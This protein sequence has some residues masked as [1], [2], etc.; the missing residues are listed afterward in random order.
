MDGSELAF[1]GIA[2]QA[3]LIRAREV[4]SREL[5]ELCLERIDRLD[6][7]L[8]AFRVVLSDS[9]LTEA[10]RADALGEDDGEHPL[11]GV[12]IAVK[13]GVDVAGQATT[14]G[15]G[16]HG[17]PATR[18]AEMVRRLRAAGAIVIGKTHLPELALWPFTESATWG[19]TRNPWDTD[20]TPGG[21][22]GGSAA[23]VAAGLV[24]AATASDGAGSI[25]I[26]AASCGLFGLKPQR[27]RVSLLP[28]REHWHGMSVNGCLTRTVADTAAFLDATM[29][30]ADGDA[31][32]ARPPAVPFAEA[33]RTAPGRLC[34]ALS[35]KTPFIA[36]LGQEM[37]AAV[38]DAGDLLRSLGH[39]VVERDPEWGTIAP[40]ATARYLR[41]AHDDAA[42]I[43][44]PARLER[45]TRQIA[46]LGGLVHPAL[47]ARARRMEAAQAARVNAVLTDH[48]VL[49]TPVIT[50][51]AIE[52]GRYEAR[53]ALTTLAGV[54]S[55]YGG[56]YTVVWNATGQPAASV[57]TGFTPAGLPLAVQIVGRPHDE[58]TLLSLAAQIEAERPW[59]GR[60][61][62]VS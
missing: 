9:A 29:G 23:A 55:G 3:E 56:P 51:P 17:P 33:A 27:G 13:D 57:P 48:D 47:V 21:S 1:A 7:Q 11:R 2:R 22:S 35:L 16:A 52:V 15:T 30:A 8:N 28:A 31:D 4:S 61:P 34:V 40:G 44:R 5:V 37:R 42:R 59:A 50:E 14:H 24:G 20:R 49:L 53:G 41:G 46:R 36:R 39:E 6:P 62:P 43:A 19:V 10:D 25:R 26:P 54:T 58:A 60:R 12:P 38:H 32:S 45:R 18:D